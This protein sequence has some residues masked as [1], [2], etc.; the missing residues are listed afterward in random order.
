M[1][2][3]NCEELPCPAMLNTGNGIW[4]QWSLWSSCSMS[5]GP[6]TQARARTCSKE[7]CDGPPTQRMACNLRECAGNNNN[8][9][10]WGLWS[11]CSGKFESF[12]FLTNFGQN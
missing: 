2:I 5:C 12:V 3:R 4:S 7:P 6:G 8:W 9:G 1:D 10:A 11:Q